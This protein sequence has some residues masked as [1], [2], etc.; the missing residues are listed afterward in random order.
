MTPGLVFR[1]VLRNYYFF[2]KGMLSRSQTAKIKVEYVG[3]SLLKNFFFLHL[4][5]TTGYGV[6]HNTQFQN[7]HLGVYQFTSKNLLMIHE[8]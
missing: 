5:F 1:L 4:F 6:I 7:G 3:L 8:T 2:I